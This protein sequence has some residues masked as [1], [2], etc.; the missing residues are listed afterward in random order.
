MKKQYIFN[1]KL[2]ILHK[3]EQNNL[4]L[5]KIKKAKSFLDL[6]CPESFTFFKTQFKG[7]L[8]KNKCIY[9]F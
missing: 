4:L 8:T 2:H 6:K 5:S 3:E 9:I 7:G 1:R